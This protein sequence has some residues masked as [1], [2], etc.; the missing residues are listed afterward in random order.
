M[1]VHYYIKLIVLKVFFCLNPSKAGL[2][3]LRFKDVKVYK[4]YKKGGGGRTEVDRYATTLLLRRILA[5]R[6]R[7]SLL[8][9]TASSSALK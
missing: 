9:L 4:E 6:S 3:I 2:I 7:T 8:S 1:L 5:L